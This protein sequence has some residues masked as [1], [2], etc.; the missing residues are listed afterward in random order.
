MRDFNIDFAP[1]A[2]ALLADFTKRNAFHIGLCTAFLSENPES[3]L[4]L[5]TQFRDNPVQVEQMLI[6]EA[7]NLLLQDS[8]PALYALSVVMSQ[9]SEPCSQ[10]EIQQIWTL[11]GVQSPFPA[12][13]KPMLESLWRIAF[14]KSDDENFV[15]R[16][17]IQTAL[18]ARLSAD[19]KQSANVAIS[20]FYNQSELPIGGKTRKAFHHLAKAGMLREAMNLAIAYST[21]F[22]RTG[23]LESAKNLVVAA[24]DYQSLLDSNLR[25]FLRHQLSAICF[26]LGDM[27]GAVNALESVVD[28]LKK[29][30]N[31]AGRLSAE[32]QLAGLYA[33][34]G[35]YDA[36]IEKYESVFA[37]H[38]AYKN[39]A[40]IAATAT[41]EGMIYFQQKHF[42]EAVEKFY[43]A[44]LLSA[45]LSDDE[46]NISRLNWEYLK[47][48]LDDQTFTALLEKTKDKV[49]SEARRYA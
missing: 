16:S 32:Q 27:I 33:A 34:Q 39:T 6:S 47:S 49:E 42:S 9:L 41:Q 43:L 8:P 40:G 2:S 15:L 45:S 35:R 44:K 5:E 1:D 37:E 10:K 11:L 21:E 22:S 19:D 14:L 13:V 26:R 24:L 30:D 7:L 20:N 23:D 17:E 31:L 36:A 25:I 4:D 48:E 12:E 29:T 28:D 3:L 18:E 46:K 38:V